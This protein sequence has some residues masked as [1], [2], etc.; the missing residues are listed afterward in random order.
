M[1][2]QVLEG[3]TTMSYPYDPAAPPLGAR[4]V[5]NEFLSPQQATAAAASSIVGTVWS[6]HRHREI[7]SP[8]QHRKSVP[9]TTTC[10]LTVA[11]FVTSVLQVSGGLKDNARL[12]TC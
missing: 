3:Y 11:R 5:A 4:H 6:D 10:I 1:K 7:T 2:S 12:M 8:F 9:I